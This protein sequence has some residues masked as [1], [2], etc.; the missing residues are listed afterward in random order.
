M[1]GMNIGWKRELTSAM[2][3]MLM[4]KDKNEKNWGFDRFDDIWAG[5]FV[6]KIV[7]I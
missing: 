6:K 1:C 3:F 5:I 7:I 4:G 2:Y